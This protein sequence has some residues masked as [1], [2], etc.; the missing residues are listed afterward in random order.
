[1]ADWFG[2]SRSNYFRVKDP[3]Q[4][5]EEMATFSGLDVRQT[6]E[7]YYALFGDDGYGGWPSASYNEETGDESDFD[8]VEIVSRHLA[9]GEVAVFMSAGAEKLRYISGYSEAVDHTGKRVF[10]SLNDIYE[11]AEEAFGVRPS[12]AE[13]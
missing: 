8:I 10:V 4:F 3:A 2:T 6:K 12:S 9:E 7:G 11:K 5:E 1:M 13:Y